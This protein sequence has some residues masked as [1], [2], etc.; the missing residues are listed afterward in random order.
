MK[1]LTLKSFHK[2]LFFYREIFYPVY[3]PTSIQIYS[4]LLALNIKKI[5][6]L[7]YDPIKKA[8]EV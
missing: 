3:K 7:D 6:Q 4:V 2:F 8:L 5:G 1:F